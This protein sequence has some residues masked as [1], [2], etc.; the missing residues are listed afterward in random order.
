MGLKEQLG[1]EPTRVGDNIFTPSPT[2]IAAMKKAISG[3]KAHDFGAVYA[4]AQKVLLVCTEEDRLEMENG[5]FFLTGNH[6]VE[7]YVPLLHMESVGIGFDIAT[8][9]GKSAKLEEWAIPDGDEAIAAILSRTESRRNAPITLQAAAENMLR[10]DYCA[11]FI[12]GGHGAI[13]GL[14]E[15]PNLKPILGHFM[16]AGQP[17][18]SLC[19]G[20][21]TFLAAA[22]SV[23]EPDAE[24]LFNGYSIA[25]FP[26]FLDRQ[27]PRTGYLP[28]QM[29]WF[30]CERLEA[31]G[32]TVVNKLA[33][34]ATH[35]DRNVITGDGPMAANELGRLS[36]EAILK[37]AG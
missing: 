23:A 18:I 12:P 5:T 17:V 27:L 21:A 11:L 4:G 28:G 36:V 24:F 29:P 35:V 37:G 16:A 22:D 9:T 32:V 25:A 10:G 33:M 20:P 26:D 34:G 7:T 19:H 2:S 6:P 1:M 14:P 31:L 13:K 30:F 8:P 15:D 3:Y